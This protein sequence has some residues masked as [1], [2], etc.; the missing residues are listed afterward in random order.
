MTIGQGLRGFLAFLSAVLYIGFIIAIG[1]VSVYSPNCE[2]AV[3]AQGKVVRGAE[4]GQPVCAKDSEGNVKPADPPQIH[5]EVA[6][7]LSIM[8][9]A[10][11]VH[12]GTVL[13]LET[14][15]ARRAARADAMERRQQ[16]GGLLKWLTDSA[17]AAQGLKRLWGWLCKGLLW[18]LNH[19][20]ET[21]ALVYVLG[22]LIAV[23]FHFF[24][25]S[26]SE[27]SVPFL[28]DSWTALVGIFAGI[29]AARSD[30]A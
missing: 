16:A 19:L 27:A 28:R 29:W 23:G 21:A 11:A 26:F 3:D 17:K 13:G 12:T 8:S 4:S 7:L 2:Y 10:L 6:T 24:G 18:V 1:V 22:I 14:D 20:P 15:P 30:E 9:T 25:E 5:T